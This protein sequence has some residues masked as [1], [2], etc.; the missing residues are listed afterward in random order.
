MPRSACH[1][2]TSPYQRSSATGWPSSRRSTT[3]ARSPTRGRSR[4]RATPTWTRTFR[5][6]PRSS[7]DHRYS[8]GGD[9]EEVRQTEGASKDAP[10]YL[11]SL[12]GR[13]GCGARGRERGRGGKD[14]RAE[15]NS[16]SCDPSPLL[17]RLRDIVSRRATSSPSTTFRTHN[18]HVKSHTCGS[19]TIKSNGT[20][21]HAQ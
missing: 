2:L 15:M 18:V 20:V 21:Q 7:S 10:H 9:L 3:A 11:T 17:I 6:C 19:R 16:L 4:T 14:A 5:S 12:A 13:R 8:E 1:Y